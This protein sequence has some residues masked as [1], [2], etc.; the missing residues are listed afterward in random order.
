MVEKDEN[1][2]AALRYV[3]RLIEKKIEVTNLQMV[4][5]AKPIAHL[6]FACERSSLELSSGDC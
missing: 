5:K 2:L 1:Q 6:V 4:S 3:S